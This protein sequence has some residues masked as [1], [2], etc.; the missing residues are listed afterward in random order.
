MRL[1]LVRVG[2][3]LFPS[4]A[5]D[6]ALLWDVTEA[7]RDFALPADALELTR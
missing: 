2:V 1:P 7:L 5:Y 6:Q 3:S 4:Q